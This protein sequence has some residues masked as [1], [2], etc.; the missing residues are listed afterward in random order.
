MY[1]M[2]NTWKTGDLEVIFFKEQKTELVSMAVLPAGTSE[3]IVAH[4]TGISDTV[5]AKSICKKWGFEFPA[6]NLESLFQ[7]KFSGDFSFA[8]H[9]PGLDMRNSTTINR[10][11]LIS[12]EE[13]G[14][15]FCSI[16]ESE[17]KMKIIHTLTRPEGFRFLECKTEFFN[18]SGES[19]RVELFTSFSLGMISLFHPDDAPGALKLHRYSTFWSSEA[20]HLEHSFD[21]LNMGISW[22]SAGVRA[23]RYGQRSSMV[24][25]QYHPFAAVEDTKHGIVWAAALEAT[26]PW[27]LVISR[28]CDFVNIS[29]GLPD[30][31][32]AG[33]FKDIAPGETLCSPTA[34]L[35]ACC[36]SCSDAA[37]DLLPW[38]KTEEPPQVMHPTFSDWCTTWG[39]PAEERLLKIAPITAELGV[40]YF[41]LDAGWFRTDEPGDWTLKKELYPRG[42]KAFSES[43]EEYGMKS[44]LWFEFENIYPREVTLEKSGKAGWVHTL[45]GYPLRSGDAYFLDFRK[46]EVIAH[47]TEKVAT[48]LRE[49]NVGYI[50]I[51][52]NSAIPFGVDGESA[53]PAENLQQHAAC[54]RKFHEDLHRL[55]PGLRIEECSSGGN[56]LTPGWAKTGEYISCSDAHEGVEIPILAAESLNFC[57]YDK[58]LVWSTLRQTDDDN[59]LSYSM[60]AG[61]MGQM[62]LSGDLDLLSAEQLA[63]VRK[64]VSFYEKITPELRLNSKLRIDNNSSSRNYPV[65]RQNMTLE[66]DQ[67]LLQIVHFF[68]TDALEA[69][70]EL[71]AG[72]WVLEDSIKADS[73]DFEISGG[74]VKFTKVAPFSAAALR[75]RRK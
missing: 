14:N 33:W 30:R 57:Y 18:G 16:F 47:L 23:L 41:Q 36:G 4:R 10:F 20:K 27:E 32:F 26:S 65:G 24:N 66:S 12:Q 35:T 17:D 73:L 70:F 64:Y 39:T 45:D 62:A 8:Q 74:T 13:N 22:Q 5:A 52:Y 40:K 54:V 48:F 56:R 58:A 60:C 68:E 9:G 1:D 67:E 59:R 63:T 25:K 53:S 34:L 21:E 11:K 31:E 61:M 49:N 46:P 42:F 28:Y 44:G 7:I 29:G 43:L 15:S 19:R 55:V 6:N 2:I 38:Q 75:Y 37:R 72:D 69:E 3:K 51:D 71:P 50:K